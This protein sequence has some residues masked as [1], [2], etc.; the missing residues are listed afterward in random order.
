[1]SRPVVALLTDFGV[2]D[3]YA[4]TM[5]GV[6]I[7]ACPDVTLVDI[8]HDVAPQDVLGG[9]LELVAAYRHFPP[10]TVFLVVID[11]GVGSGRRALA[12]Q[13]GGY[14]FVAPDNGVL[15][16]VLD[17]QRDHRIVALS[18]VPG[19]SRT[20]EGRDR[21]GPAAGRLAA[22]ATLASLGPPAGEIQRLRLPEA[23]VGPDGVEGEVIRVDHFGNLMTNIARALVEP[24]WPATVV[25]DVAGCRIHGM[26]GTYADAPPGTLCALVDSTDRLEIAVASGSAA[27][28]LKI[29]RGAVVRVRRG[30]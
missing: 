11:P 6:V 28:R 29:G 1:M 26:A 12:A 25:V 7:G 27:A 22:G 10:G 14:R 16:P 13:A 18:E 2:R 30:A 8:T 17:E 15:S 4:G 23:R 21:L 3:H 5:K 9:A 24:L 19:S 20:F